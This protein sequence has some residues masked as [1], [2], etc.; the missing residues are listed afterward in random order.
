MGG[1]AY[2]STDDKDRADECCNRIDSLIC[3]IAAKCGIALKLGEIGVDASAFPD[4]IDS[5]EVN[6][7]ILSCARNISK[8]DIADILDKSY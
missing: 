4:I 6:G 2:L 8:A 7:A 5:A 3:D 1:E